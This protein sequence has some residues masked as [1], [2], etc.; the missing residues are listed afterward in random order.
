MF[1]RGK[2]EKWKSG[3]VAGKLRQNAMRPVA[4]LLAALV[5]PLLLV[6]S[7]LRAQRVAADTTDVLSRVAE[8]VDTYY[9]RAQSILAVETVRVQQVSRDRTSDGAFADEPD[10]ARGAASHVQ[11]ERPWGQLTRSDST[12]SGAPSSTASGSM[13]NHVA[14]VA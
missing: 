1:A 6:G 13:S 14:S 4:A 5:L 11:A 9:S 12:G 7:P 10:G 8:Y 3:K 2:R